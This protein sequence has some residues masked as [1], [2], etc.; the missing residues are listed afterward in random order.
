[1]TFITNILH[2]LILFQSPMPVAQGRLKWSHD[3][4]V[5]MM[6]HTFTNALLYFFVFRGGT[7]V[8]SMSEASKSAA[9]G[10]ASSGVGAT[11]ASASGSAM[12]TSMSAMPSAGAN[13]T[14]AGAS[15][16]AASASASTG[17]S[18]STSGT[19][20]TYQVASILAVGAG[21][22]AVVMANM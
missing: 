2:V 15:S 8:C 3:N 7:I 6:S 10:V 12:M 17:S 22:F 21:L 16:G 19:Q 11:M 1:M 13:S 9:A 4:F 5:R 18:G 14:S 20:H